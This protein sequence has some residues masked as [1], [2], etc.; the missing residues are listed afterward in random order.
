MRERKK[1]VTL[2]ATLWELE[3]WESAGRI[4]RRDLPGF[5]IF[6][7]NATARYIRELYRMRQPDAVLTR[8][9]EKKKL[10]ALLKAARESVEHLPKVYHSPIHGPRPV[11]ANLQNAVDEVYS[12]LRWAG[13]EYPCD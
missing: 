8:Q 6:A 4:A 5:L 7:A 13:E 10:G 3:S 11:R 1:T 12:F 9:E 2:K